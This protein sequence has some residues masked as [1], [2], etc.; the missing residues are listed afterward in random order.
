M[1]IH[2]NGYKVE[3]MQWQ[4]Q[5]NIICEAIAVFVVVAAKPDFLN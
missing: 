5:I 1:H 4:H 3:G 2:L